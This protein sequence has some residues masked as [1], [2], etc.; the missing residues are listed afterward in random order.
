MCGKNETKTS[1]TAPTDPNVT[2]AYD[3]LL[4]KGQSLASQPLQLYGGQLVAPLNATQNSAINSIQNSQNLA[5]PYLTEAAQYA[6]QGSTPITSTPFTQANIDQYMSPYQNDVIG[7]TQKL[8]QQQDAQQQQTLQGNIT[9]A[10]AW[11]GDRSA[12]LQS[13]LGGQQALANNSTLAGLENTGYQQ[14]LGQ[15]N[16]TNQLGLQTQQAN[17]QN[18]QNT[19]YS[20][21]SL[22]TAMQNSA[23]TGANSLLNAGTL[24]QQ[25]AQENLNVPYEQYLQQQAFPYQSLDFEAGLLPGIQQGTGTTSTQTTP[26]ANPFSQLLGL[27]T[28]AIGAFGA[29][30]GRVRDGGRIR[31]AD[32]GGGL[33][34]SGPSMLEMLENSQMT[35][36]SGGTGGGF[37]PPPVVNAGQSFIPTAAPTGGGGG[38]QPANFGNTPA[39]TDNLGTDAGKFGG[40]LYDA[41]NR[42]SA[43]DSMDTQVAELTGDTGSPDLGGG[44][45]GG[46]FNSIFGS[47]DGGRVANGGRTRLD[48]GGTAPLV[49]NPMDPGELR[50][51]GR[52]RLADGG[53]DDYSDDMDPTDPRM[54]LPAGATAM[55]LQDTPPDWQKL[56]TN[57]AQPDDADLAAP[58]NSLATSVPTAPGG[59]SL[60]SAQPTWDDGTP[61]ATDGSAPPPPSGSAG[62]GIQH[63]AQIMPQL[64]QAKPDWHRALMTAGAAMMAGRS[65]NF[66]ENVGSGVQ[67]GVNEYYGQMDKDNHPEVDHSG[68]TSL[69][70][71]ADGTVVDTGLPTEAAINAKSTLDYRTANMQSI[72]AARDEATAQRAAAADAATRERAQAAADAAANRATQLQIAREGAA[73]GRFTFQPGTSID[74]NTNQPVQGT[75]VQNTRTGDTEFRPGNVLTGK[76]PAGGAGGISGR[77]SVLFNRVVGAANA[78]T[79]AAKNIMEL[80]STVNRGLLG[81][82]SQGPGI[83]DT[84]KSDLSNTLT[85]SDAQEYNTMMAGVSRNLSAIEASGLAPNGSL[86]HSMDS[87]VMKAG[88]TQMTKLRKMAEMRQIVETGLEPNLSNPRIPQQQKDLVTGIIGQMRQAIPYTQHDVTALEQNKNPRATIGDVV[89]QRSLGQQTGAAPPIPRGVPAGS[90]YSPSRRQWRDSTGQIYGADG[91]PSP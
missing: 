75:Y 91:Q 17:N 30:G 4:S 43:P 27:G 77:E 29:D 18:A 39:S 3:S 74:P 68:P 86:T 28:A 70:R 48:D 53:A 49:I 12:V 90:Q 54:L 33:Q 42:P 69:I 60:S 55:S 52:A 72:K 1:T 82:Q 40:A 59:A 11:G 31:R 38:M 50:R 26:G 80:P 65:Q 58:P 79:A 84:L 73:Q 7:A 44:G 46:F 19:A 36:D 23:L 51:G 2:A 5:Q 88:D 87:L 62:W 15:F 21:G 22:G 13:Q 67:A 61:V 57:Y 47:H 24:Q 41:I 66:G 63:A 9:A 10:G 34:A 85:D 6:Q 20:L 14:A 56:A 25:V 83:M 37:A 78:A 71:Y 89:K 64:Y 81:G 76:E 32:G 16:T 8:E 35:R 45:I